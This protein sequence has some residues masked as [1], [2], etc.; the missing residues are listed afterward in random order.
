V[1]AYLKRYVPNTRYYIK[2]TTDFIEKINNIGPLP[3]GTILATM[4]VTSLYTNIPTHGGLVAI[5]DY[6]RR[7][8]EV[9][10]IGPH[11]LKLHMV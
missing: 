8:P 2:Y 11:L 1:D 10:R 5:A 3:Q 6:L 4:D 9:D 7:D